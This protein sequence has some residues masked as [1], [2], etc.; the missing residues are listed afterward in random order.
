MNF[1]RIFLA[2]KFYR[3]NH[4]IK[5]PEVFVIDE[6][7]NPVGK[8]SSYE[9]RQMAERAELDLVEVSP[10]A[11]PPV[12]KIIDF[13]KFKYE[14]EKLAR[15]QKAKN[16]GQELKEIRFSV[17]IEENDYQVK[18]N[19]VKGFLEKRHKVKISMQLRGREMAFQDKAREMMSNIQKSLEE[20][21]KVEQPMKRLGKQFIMILAPD[22]KPKPKPSTGTDAKAIPENKETI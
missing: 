17:R 19:R 20:I 6:N 22:S 9:A 13:G 4:M 2:K 18:L 14:I 7:S 1:E 16:K 8:I 3:I 11:R 21:S 12:C 10:N 15:K 5:A